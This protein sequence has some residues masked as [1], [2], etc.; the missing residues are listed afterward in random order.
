ML[1]SDF[2]YAKKNVD[3][4]DST[5]NITPSRFMCCPKQRLFPVLHDYETQIL[6]TRLTI[7]VTVA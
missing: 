3:L 7:I 2:L 6:R 1:E 4:T 5:N